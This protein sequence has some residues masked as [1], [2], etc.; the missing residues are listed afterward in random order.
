M[1]AIVSAGMGGKFYMGVASY[2]TL[3]MFGSTFSNVTCEYTTY[4]SV[5]RIFLWRFCCPY[6][7]NVVGRC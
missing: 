1:S 4:F 3:A 6:L 5:L 7:P 2:I